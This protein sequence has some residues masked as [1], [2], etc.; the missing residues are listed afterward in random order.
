MG[1]KGNHI[2]H[3]NDLG[4]VESACDVK[5]LYATQ[6]LLKFLRFYDFS[7]FLF[8]VQVNEIFEKI[9]SNLSY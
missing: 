2:K 3:F 6:K 5:M 8:H 7:R 1:F 4:V 9:A